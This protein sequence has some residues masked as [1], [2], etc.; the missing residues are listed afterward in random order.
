M[1]VVGVWVHTWK[2]EREDEEFKATCHYIVRSKSVTSVSKKKYDYIF[3]LF[4][5][6]DEHT[7]PKGTTGL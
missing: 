7:V 2:V 5:L 4:L 3:Q 1:T 6:T